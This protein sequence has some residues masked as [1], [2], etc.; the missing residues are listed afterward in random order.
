MGEV[1]DQNE[2]MKLRK[3]RLARSVRKM[4]LERAIL[5]ECLAKRMRKNGTD[6][7][8]GVFD[9]DSD[10]SSDESPPTA[11]GPPPNQL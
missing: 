1:E 8:N 4:R 6:G 9:E 10:D 2:A 7:L 5:L 3:S 11:S